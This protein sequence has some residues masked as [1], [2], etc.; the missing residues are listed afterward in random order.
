MTFYT[1][2]RASWRHLQ[3]SGKNALNVSCDW[4]K[5]EGATTMCWSN[6]PVN[7]TECALMWLQWQERIIS[8][9]WIQ[10]PWQCKTIHQLRRSGLPWCKL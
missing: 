2:G 5:M 1:S 10:F 7:E 3:L 9:F 4:K 8:N 6:S